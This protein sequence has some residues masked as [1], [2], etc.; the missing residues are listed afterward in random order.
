MD[1]ATD[2]NIEKAL[3][4]A[5]AV[6]PRT[7]RNGFGG[8]GVR[9]RREATAT[10]EVAV[11]LTRY[12]GHTYT[13]YENDRKVEKSDVEAFLADELTAVPDDL[14]KTFADK[15]TLYS[16]PARNEIAA[17]LAKAISDKWRWTYKPSDA[18]HL[19]PMFGD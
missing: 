8:K 14:A 2:D 19:K 10:F 9:R 17:R 18:I 7:F 16:E 15:L 3:R 5:L 11:V 6:V 1:P 4:V 13:F 12:L